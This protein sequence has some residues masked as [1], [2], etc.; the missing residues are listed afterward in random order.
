MLFL[1]RNNTCNSYK[2]IWNS[3]HINCS[4]DIEA[5]PWNIC[6]CIFDC[7]SL[8]FQ[9]YPLTELRIIIYVLLCLY[10]WKVYTPFK[11]KFE[12]LLP[13]RIFVN[14]GDY[15][16]NCHITSTGSVCH[17]VYLCVIVINTYSINNIIQYG[18]RENSTFVYH[19][20]TAQWTLTGAQWYV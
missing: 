10:L 5:S 2:I 13:F 19:R 6:G 17:Q 20:L 8:I 18:T 9:A 14:C 7:W 1:N 11:N 15:C 4:M 12:F 16:H 3:Y